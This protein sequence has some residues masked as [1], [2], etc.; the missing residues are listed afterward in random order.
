MVALVR[1][2]TVLK[3]SALF[4]GMDWSRIDLVLTWTQVTN[5]V[6]YVST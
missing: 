2:A 5:L 3:S 1:E 4:Q 6:T